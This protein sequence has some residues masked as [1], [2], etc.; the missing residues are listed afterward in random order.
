M[1]LTKVSLS[2]TDCLCALPRAIF[3]PAEAQQASEEVMSENPMSAAEFAT[4]LAV[5]WSVAIVLYL[6]ALRRFAARVTRGVVICCW[7]VVGLL[8][9]GLLAQ[10]IGGVTSGTFRL[11]ET[12]EIALMVGIHAS[13]LVTR[14]ERLALL[15]LTAVCTAMVVGLLH[16]F[17][18]ELP[19]PHNLAA[20]AHAAGLVVILALVAW[21]AQGS[22]QRIAPNASPAL[23]TPG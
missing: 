10:W 8:T 15:A 3:H 11:L 1:S 9:A 12:G 23:G 21:V 6:A 18:I 16:F 19:R 4:M 20:A 17:F 22:L 5:L 2:G 7:T 13:V 14:S